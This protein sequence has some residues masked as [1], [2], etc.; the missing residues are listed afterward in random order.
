MERERKRERAGPDNACKHA[1]AACRQG[2]TFVAR[3]RG[4]TEENKECED[5]K[6][7]KRKKGENK[8]KERGKR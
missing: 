4:K 8:K 6:K 2:L 1:S 5:K 3:K 7:E